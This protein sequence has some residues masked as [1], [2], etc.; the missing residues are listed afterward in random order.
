MRLKLQSVKKFKKECEE[1]KISRAYMMCIQSKHQE[2]SLMI[3][4]S[5]LVLTA[6][7]PEDGPEEGLIL[8]YETPVWSEMSLFIDSGSRRGELAER[9]DI[10]K[11]EAMKDLQGLEVKEGSFEK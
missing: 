8:T 4:S 9:E 3:I 5:K 7:D 10:M 2:D 11:K 1:R 6:L